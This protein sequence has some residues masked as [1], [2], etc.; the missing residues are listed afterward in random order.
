MNI[1]MRSIDGVGNRVVARRLDNH[2]AYIS[3]LVGLVG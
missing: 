3:L 1:A 2:A